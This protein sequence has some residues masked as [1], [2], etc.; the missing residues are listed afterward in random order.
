MKT[1]CSPQ[2]TEEGI[3]LDEFYELSIQLNSK[4]PVKKILDRSDNIIITQND[5]YILI[6]EASRKTELDHMAIKP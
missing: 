3:P 5:F 1:I 4:F 2:K 6:D